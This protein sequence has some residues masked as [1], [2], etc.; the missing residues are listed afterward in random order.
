MPPVHR[1]LE[2]EMV[3]TPRVL[4]AM[5]LGLV[6]AGCAGDQRTVAPSASTPAYTPQQIAGRWGLASFR[7]EED[8]ARTEREARAQCSNPYV[9]EVGPSGGVI[10]HLADVAEPQEL[11]IKSSGGRTFIGPE[12]AAGQ[13]A[14][15]EIVSLDETIMITTWMDPDV[16]ERYGTMLFVRC[17]P[18]S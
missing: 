14:D 17:T 13:A 8:R 18:R 10:M 7:K 12:G 4:V 5:V 6:L 1:A 2:I 11:R 16:A 9:I 15:R 3:V